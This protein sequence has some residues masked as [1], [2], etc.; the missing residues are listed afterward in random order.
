M[1]VLRYNR[2]QNDMEI[3]QEMKAEDYQFFQQNGYLSLGRILTDEE[4]GFYLHLYDQDRAEKQDFWFDYGHHHQTANYDVLVSTPE[5]DSLVRHPKVMRPLNNLMENDIC[6]SEIG[7]RHMAAYTG[8]PRH[9][10]WHRDGDVHGGR[11]L[12]GHPLRI[13]NVQLMVYLS[14][15]D[16]TTH[17]F[18]I[19]PES[20]DQPVLQ[21][22]E[23]L[24]KG[25]IHNLHGQAGTA[26]LFNFSVLHTA[27]VRVTQKERKTAQIYYGHRNRP[28]MANDS[29]IPVDFWRDHPDVEV[30]AFYGVLNDKTR[31][32]LEIAGAK[33]HSLKGSAEILYEIDYKNRR[34]RS[35]AQNA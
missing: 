20:V 35:L 21:K 12:M 22:G 32:Y 34:K 15:V 26:V 17:C 13:R 1:R 19:S 27:T 3:W 14:D 31:K 29:L 16:E 6:F 7:I 10:V 11:H 33:K 30:R 18:S 4:L 9:C 25:G 5:F 8:E 24:K 23:Q 28:H 2:M